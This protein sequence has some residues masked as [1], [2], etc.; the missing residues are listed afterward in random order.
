MISKMFRE[1]KLAINPGMEYSGLWF[2]IFIGWLIKRTVIRYGGLK[3]YRS[4]RNIFLGMILGESI[5]AIPWA[6]V[7]FVTGR[8]YNFFTL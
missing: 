3:M 2:S 4:A 5:V 7:G 6:V 1:T 8:G